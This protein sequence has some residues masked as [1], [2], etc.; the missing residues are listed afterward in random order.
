MTNSSTLISAFCPTGKLRASI[1]LGNPILA[2]LDSSGKA[3]GVSIDLAQELAN[4]LG[5]ELEL[6]VFT[7]AVQ[8]VEAV[9]EEKADIGFFAIDPLRGAEIA[10]THPYVLIEGYFLVRNSSP[11]I[12]NADVDQQGNRVIVGAGS[13]YDLFLSRELKQ[14]DIIRATSSQ[15]V[16]STF[17]ELGAEVAAGVKQQLESDAK[18][19]DG[20]RLLTQNFMIIQQAMGLPKTRGT[21]AAQYLSQF[22]EQ[23]KATGFVENALLR[24]GIAG[25][26]VAPLAR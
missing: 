15:T 9:N 14:A 11:I 19:Y 3:V 24:H 25:A 22:V 20:F 2:N 13:A 16:V 17:V 23:M 1:N 10:F 21:I 5:V 18:Q 8:S 4:R 12:N 26:S 7:K 6:L